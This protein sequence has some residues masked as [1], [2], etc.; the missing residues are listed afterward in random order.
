[1]I[2][3]DIPVKE[4]QNDLFG[5][6][7]LAEKIASG[8]R[9]YQD[10][11]GVVIG[12]YGQWGSGKTSMLNFIRNYLE[13]AGD[14]NAPP[15]LVI[16]FNPWLFSHR[17]D[18]IVRFF[19]Q[20][21]QEFKKYELDGKFSAK[22][23]QI[24]WRYFAQYSLK[25]IP[26]PDPVSQVA[27]SMVSDAIGVSNPTLEDIK[28]KIIQN[29]TELDFRIV[30]M[31][32]DV[33]RLEPDEIRQIFQLVKLVANFPNIIYIIALDYKQ[34]VSS[35]LAQINNPQQ[36][37]EKIIQVPFNMPH[38]SKSILQNV[39]IDKLNHIF[40]IVQPHE[41]DQAYWNT[42]FPHVSVYFDTPRDVVRMM[43][44][45]SMTYSLNAK[46]VNVVDFF[47]I[48]T[49]RVFELDLYEHLV[50]NQDKLV[51]FRNMSDAKRD[52]EMQSF[53][54]ECA[55]KTN[56][57]KESVKKLLRIIF[58]IF[59]VSADDSVMARKSMRI[60]HGD[61]F[62]NYFTYAMNQYTVHPNTL[63]KLMIATRSVDELIQELSQYN[64]QKDADGYPLIFQV[65][66][67]WVGEL[68]THTLNSENAQS[69]VC[70][71]LQIG[72]KL[73]ELDYSDA[74]NK[75]PKEWLLM[76][77]M[78]NAVNNIKDKM[79]IPTL[80]ETQ[81]SNPTSIDFL[82]IVIDF[83]SS[84]LQNHRYQLPVDEATK[85][86]QRWSEY[87]LKPDQFSK[88]L[89]AKYA[90]QNL[91]RLLAWDT[92]STAHTVIQKFLE[93]DDG[94]LLLTIHA[95]SKVAIHEYGTIPRTRYEARVNLQMITKFMDVETLKKRLINIKHT[96]LDTGI[97][98]Y[99]EQFLNALSTPAD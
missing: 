19:H 65:L 67:L 98:S 78:D 34:T 14:Q 53:L 59:K 74:W 15:A 83:W 94:L 38:I 41:F 17:D 24:N 8:I 22:I 48:E 7:S 96:Q 1:M 18:L 62:T 6:A 69:I 13:K 80:L 3:S 71:M 49:L 68:R 54:E 63:Q 60:C 30:V 58:P 92:D 4:V 64:E 44:T 35:M 5:Y 73:L 39:L 95:F 21:E 90:F 31:I 85:L 70:A 45:F 86:K 10:K 50:V 97:V 23:K 36:Y 99:I 27:L 87:V 75:I 33:D 79:I 56:E 52:Q 26:T 16:L 32:D 89:T 76:Q 43:N 57:Y 40:E 51:G 81:L 61:M 20:L 47:V 29:L 91:Q 25:L 46:N 84:E 82:G 11:D 42:V 55:G 28:D 12:L 2:N 77:V 37:L 88:I 72:N 9:N 93:S 66:N